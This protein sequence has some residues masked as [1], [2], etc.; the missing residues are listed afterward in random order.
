M[1]HFR[2]RRVGASTVAVKPVTLTVIAEHAGCSIAQVSSVLNHARGGTVVSR[3][4]SERIRAVAAELGYRPN[5][6]S[7][8]LK[9]NSM[10]TIGIYMEPTSLRSLGNI[11]ESSIYR[12]IE[13]AATRRDYDILIFNLSCEVPPEVCR[14]KLEESRCDGVVLLGTAPRADWLDELVRNGQ[15]LVAVDCARETGGL[16][17]I[18][19]DDEEAIALAL[20]ELMKLGHSRIGFL[21]IGLQDG[22]YQKELRKQLFR[23]TVLRLGG[24]P[25]PALIFDSSVCPENI[26]PDSEFCQLSGVFGMRYFA[27]LKRRPTALLAHDSL[28]AVAAL[29]EASALGVRIPEEISLA[30]IDDYDF[31]RLFRPALSV[32][33][34]RLPEM[35]EKA[36]DLL[37]DLIE[38]KEETPVRSIVAPRWISR[39]SCRLL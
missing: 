17:R 3:Q 37:I 6:A 13:R 28:V 16:S 1:R 12:G 26:A 10:R 5:F 4:K 18:D 31:L 20:S 38:K 27:G 22:I 8:A 32:V 2:N 39:D 24:D 11:Y 23:K 34:H 7:R 36:A 33:D 14:R 9:S 21:G 29:Q 30:G 25:D 19:F 35:G 15:N